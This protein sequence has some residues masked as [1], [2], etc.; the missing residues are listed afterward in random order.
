EVLARFDMELPNMRAAL[1]WAAEAREAETLQR[2]CLALW[3]HWWVRR[4]ISESQV[5]LDA[6][7]SLPEV[8]PVYECELRYVSGSFALGRGDL[9]AV[10][11]HAE[12]GLAL[13]EANG[14][15]FWRQAQMMLLGHTM[16]AAGRPKEAIDLYERALQIV[17][18]LLSEKPFA[19][20]VLAF[21]SASLSAT[22]YAVEDLEQANAKAEEALAIWRDRGDPWGV[23]IALLNLGAIAAARGDFEQAAEHYGDAICHNIESGDP[24]GIAEGLN[25]LAHA[26]MHY[27]LG[28]LTARLLGARDRLE[29]DA[30]QPTPAAITRDRINT[31]PPISDSAGDAAFTRAIDE[32]R[33]LSNAEVGELTQLAVASVR[34]RAEALT[35]TLPR[36]SSG[37]GLTTRESQVLRLVAEGRTDQAIADE[38][39]LARRTVTSHLTSI[40]NK[41]G[42]ENRAAATAHAIRSGLI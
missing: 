7:L 20:H 8:K 16:R 30:E 38:L 40:F 18:E 34:A 21:L 9:T 11:R 37:G 5:W 19:S 3:K 36:A 39:Y 17:T 2:L 10:R 27:D 32:G 28:E 29:P 42:V 23:G 41:L 33:Q 31:A 6:A 12:A 26:A 1:A 24:W 25:G 22:F 13:A 14:D 35:Q 15:A 4:H